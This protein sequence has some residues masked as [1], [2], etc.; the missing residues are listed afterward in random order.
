MQLL[1]RVFSSRVRAEMLR[2]LF[3]LNQE[4]LHLRELVRRSG[5][6]LGTVQQELRILKAMDLVQSRRDGNRLYYRA[7]TGHP[8]Y[9]EIH[10]I[11]LKTAGLVDLLKPRLEGRGVRVAFVFGSIAQGTPGAASDV[12]LCVIGTPG[13]REIS[14]HLAGLEAEIGREI[15][16]FLLTPAE[17][18]RRVKSRDHFLLSVLKSSKLFVVGTADELAAVG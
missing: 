7:N 15:N 12:D 4:D 6:S 11:V 9:P 14:T 1:D 16:P 10:R 13:F 17:F 8:I 5:L 2:A 18:R 3:G